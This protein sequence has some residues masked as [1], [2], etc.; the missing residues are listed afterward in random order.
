M[1]AFQF[2]T[3]GWLRGYGVGVPNGALWTITVDIQF[4]I[5]SIFLAKWLK[6]RRIKTWGVII[7]LFMILDLTLEKAK[8]G[9]PELY[10]NYYN[11][12]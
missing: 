2:Y 8:G 3:G 7:G 10:T 5:V 9:Y 1:T 12:I 4:Y 11:V 6:G